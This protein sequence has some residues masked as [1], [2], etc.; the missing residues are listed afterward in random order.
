MSANS[1]TAPCLPLLN[2]ITGNGEYSRV[3]SKWGD[4]YDMQGYK[5]DRI[6]LVFSIIAP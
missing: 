3:L 6:H 1:Y 5:K 2:G 4:N